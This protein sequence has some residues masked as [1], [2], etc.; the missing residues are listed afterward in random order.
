MV[1]SF[2]IADGGKSSLGDVA[3]QL[4]TE[5]SDYPK[6]FVKLSKLTNSPENIKVFIVS[7]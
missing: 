7:K 1:L 2:S 4:G 5:E 6:I 3:L